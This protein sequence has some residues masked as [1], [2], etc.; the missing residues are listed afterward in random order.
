MK[1]IYGLCEALLMNL[2]PECSFHICPA[3]VGCT[4]LRYGPPFHIINIGWWEWYVLVFFPSV[5][6]L[7]GASMDWTCCGTSDHI[8]IRATFWG[9]PLDLS[10]TAPA[11]LWRGRALCP[12]GRTAA[13]S[14]LLSPWR[15]LLWNKVWVLSNTRMSR[16]G[17]PSTTLYCTE[18]ISVIHKWFDHQSRL[19][20]VKILLFCIFLTLD[21]FNSFHLC[22]VHII[23]GHW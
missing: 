2:F 11:V 10:I 16:Q 17:F 22:Y 8:G 12:I 1:D 23:A 20:V 9:Q 4:V 7:Q 18:M 14:R 5:C 13:I 15:R 21:Q 6:G 19:L 3:R